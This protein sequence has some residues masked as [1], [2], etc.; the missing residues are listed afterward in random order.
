[1]ELLRYTPQLQDVQRLARE[2]EILQVRQGRLELVHV[3]RGLLDAA[4]LSTPAPQVLVLLHVVQGG[5][6]SSTA[7]LRR[8]NALR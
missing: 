5:V 3:L 7:R 1:M 8:R 4:L 6:L 2:A